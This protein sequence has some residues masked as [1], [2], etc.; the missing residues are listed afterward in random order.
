MTYIVYTCNSIVTN[1]DAMTDNDKPLS[2]LQ[3]KE[4]M[5]SKITSDAKDQQV[6]NDKLGLL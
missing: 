2:Q 4:H 6:I 1:P 3:H 5:D